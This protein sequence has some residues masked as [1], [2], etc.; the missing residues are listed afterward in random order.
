MAD[1][2]HFREFGQRQV[3]AKKL[4]GRQGSFRDV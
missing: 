3:R 4:F 2:V 1:N